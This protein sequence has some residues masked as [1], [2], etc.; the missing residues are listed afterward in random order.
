M[1]SNVQ[2]KAGP[3][4]VAAPAGKFRRVAAPRTVGITGV[5][6]GG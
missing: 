1:L 2:G 6:D 4:L 3:P 5:A